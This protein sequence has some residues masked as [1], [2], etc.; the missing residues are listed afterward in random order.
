[1]ETKNQSGAADQ[2]DQ[3]KKDADLAAKNQDAD[4][5]AP[6]SSTP[7]PDADVS[8]ILEDDA[9]IIKEQPEVHQGED[10]TADEAA[11]RLR[12]PGEAEREP[13]PRPEGVGA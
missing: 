3:A 2:A 10:A 5:G 4:K 11:E 13:L 8:A 12:H 9:G 1:M 7:K 6:D